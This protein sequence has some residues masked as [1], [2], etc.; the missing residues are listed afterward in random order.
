MSSLRA[1]LSLPLAFLL[2]LPFHVYCITDEFGTV[3]LLDVYR[4]SIPFTPPMPVYV[5]VEEMARRVPSLGYQVYFADEASTPEIEK[6][7]RT[8]L[9]ILVYVYSSISDL[10]PLLEDFFMMMM[11]KVMHMLTIV[12]VFVFV[13]CS[14]RYLWIRF[15]AL[16]WIKTRLGLVGWGG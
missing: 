16:R 10:N 11:M 5:P 12:C 2:L 14:L 8:C 15:F 7:V 4:L 13:I 6:D 9:V 1:F 3:I